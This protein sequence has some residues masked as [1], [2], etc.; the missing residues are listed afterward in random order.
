[1]GDFLR[2]DQMKNVAVFFNYGGK[3]VALKMTAEQKRVIGLFALS[4]GKGAA[5]LVRVPHL[6]LPEDPEMEVL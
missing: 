2:L 3:T 1:M 6:S 5:E 4:T